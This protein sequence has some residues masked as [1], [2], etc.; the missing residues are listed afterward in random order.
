MLLCW[1]NLE[2]KIK[3]VSFRRAVP[4]NFLVEDIALKGP[5]CESLLLQ[6]HQGPK[7]WD[8]RG[9]FTLKNGVSC[10]ESEIHQTL[11]R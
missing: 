11:K 8:L 7:S 10:C 4:D 5:I 2:N 3:A 9:V 1:H 6:L